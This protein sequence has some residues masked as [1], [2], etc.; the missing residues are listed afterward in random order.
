MDQTSDDKTSTNSEFINAVQN[1]LYEIYQCSDFLKYKIA[2]QEEQLKYFGLY[3][4]LPSTLSSSRNVDVKLSLGPLEVSSIDRFVNYL[5]AKKEYICLFSLKPLPHN[6]DIFRIEF[7][8]TL[9][10]SIFF[11][12]SQ[13]VISDNIDDYVFDIACHIASLISPS[14]NRKTIP[15][16]WTSFPDVDLIKGIYLLAK[17]LK[18][19]HYVTI[20]EKAI[21]CFRS[22]SISGK[23]WAF[24]ATLLEAIALQLTQAHPDQTVEKLQKLLST[25]EQ[26]KLGDKNQ[27]KYVLTFN[28]GQAKFYTYHPENYKDAIRL[29]NEIPKPRGDSLWKKLLW[30]PLP[31]KNNIFLQYRLYYLAQANI[32]ITIAH[33]IDN[34]VDQKGKDNLANQAQTLVHKLRNEIEQRRLIIGDAF[35]EIEWRLYNAEVMISLNCQKD[36][37]NGIMAAK[38]ALGIAH[39][40]LDVRAN[41][42]SLYL[43]QSAMNSS[44]DLS[45]SHE[46]QESDQIF[47]E[48]IKTGWD[49]GFVKYRLGIIRRVQKNYAEAGILL[50]EALNPDIRDVSEN[51]IKIQIGKNQKQDST[52][53]KDDL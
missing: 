28:L 39:H 9:N 10:N 37:D 36:L 11:S 14:K 8:V 7:L 21:T 12:Q 25:Y 6:H 4:L 41:L 33:Q 31:K 43:L 22:I 17:Y 3:N 46:F 40:A 16:N 52:L 42:G 1:L 53:T 2:F 20:L 35:Q 5:K 38:N 15:L 48:L 50:N 45:V 27:R 49:P 29:F 51:T 18:G 30:L 24:Q 34:I 13:D 47:S 32:A 44:A 19:P 26:Y 23:E